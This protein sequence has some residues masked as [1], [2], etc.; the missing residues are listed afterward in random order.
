MI[1]VGRVEERERGVRTPALAQFYLELERI[2][3]AIHVHDCAIDG[4]CGSVD[5]HVR[6]WVSFMR[7]RRNDGNRTL[8]IRGRQ[9]KTRG[10]LECPCGCGIAISVKADSVE[11]GRCR[12]HYVHVSGGAVHRGH[13]KTLVVGISA[14]RDLEIRARVPLHS[15]HIHSMFGAFRPTAVVSG[16]LLWFVYAGFPYITTFLKPVPPGKYHGDYPLHERLMSETV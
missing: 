8:H 3:R 12:G 11:R 7:E 15:S 14:W 16:G 9:D 6:G 10:E 4:S 13:W 2:R 5:M 1:R